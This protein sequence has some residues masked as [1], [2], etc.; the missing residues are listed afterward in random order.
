L[1][2]FKQECKLASCIEEEEEASRVKGDS[3]W[4]ARGSHDRRGETGK[5]LGSRLIA[6]S[7]FVV[8]IERRII[9]IR[10]EM[11]TMS[12]RLAFSV[13]NCQMSVWGLE[14]G[15]APFMHSERGYPLLTT[16]LV[17]ASHVGHFDINCQITWA[18]VP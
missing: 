14:A 15:F 18:L 13:R 9:D 3:S 4:I 7:K 16:Y 17:S 12:P 5:K 11:D 10:E 1:D 2:I 6:H 8:W